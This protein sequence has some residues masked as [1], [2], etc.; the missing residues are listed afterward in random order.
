MFGFVINF[1]Y[2]C[3]LLLIT[4]KTFYMIKE[5]LIKNWKTSILASIALVA[6]LLL[7]FDAFTSGAA[8]V[9]GSLAAIVLFI[10]K[11]AK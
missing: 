3:I 9:L 6:G 1:T 7:G 10:S 11:D 5:L 4:I 2:L 8:I